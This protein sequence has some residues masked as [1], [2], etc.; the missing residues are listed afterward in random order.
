MIIYLEIVL[1]SI[2]SWLLERLVSP[3]GEVPDTSIYPLPFSLLA[4]FGSSNPKPSA[5]IIFI[6]LLH[7]KVVNFQACDSC[8]MP[9]LAFAEGLRIF[10]R[11][12]SS[13]PI[14]AMI[15]QS[16]LLSVSFARFHTILFL[17]HTT[18]SVTFT[19]ENDTSETDQCSHPHLGSTCFRSH[20]GKTSCCLFL[21]SPLPMTCR[22][23]CFL[24]TNCDLNPTRQRHN[25]NKHQNLPFALHCLF[26]NS[27]LWK[28]VIDQFNSRRWKT[29]SN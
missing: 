27:D 15:T 11:L 8:K 6:H 18:K 14:V 28:Y 21:D 23:S 22:H 24:I 17:I 3:D 10:P 12:L 19:W 26:P 13:W 1:R 29:N 20:I 2:T 16:F 7:Q 5:P 25:N 9:I 4:L